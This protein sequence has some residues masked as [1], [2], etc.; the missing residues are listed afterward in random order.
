VPTFC[1]HNRFLANCPICSSD[2]VDAVSTRRPSTPK[3]A[4]GAGRAPSGSAARG[5]RSS[6]AVR[7]RQITRE[8]EDGFRSQ[9]VPGVK[10][11]AAAER[12]A[13]EIAFACARLALLA[14]DPPG[15][16]G[17]IAG[18][19][20]REEAL[21]LAFLTAYL[22][23][24]D[25]EDPFAGVRAA[26][27]P[28]ASGQ[29]PQLDDAALGPR[30]A[31]GAARG[32]ATLVA[33]RAWAERSGSQ[34]AAF[35]GEAAW[36]PERRFA[37]A[38]ERLALPGLH[39]DARFDLLVTLGQLGLLD[40]RAGTLQL[41][42]ADETT[43]AAKRVFGI[44][45]TLLLERRASCRSRRSTSRCGTGTARRAPVPPASATAR[46]SARSASSPTP[47]HTRASPLRSA[48]NRRSRRSIHPRCT[49]E[50]AGQLLDVQRR[51]HAN[52]S[53]FRCDPGRKCSRC[54]PPL[55]DS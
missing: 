37:R 36:S 24:L 46:R 53:L 14:G 43:V 1:R 15:L 32:A 22:C 50:R 35:A 38:F 4:G 27:V 51:L 42:G 7:V 23:P 45:D 49:G 47:T 2:R 6:G 18:L 12:L 29:L 21:W 8:Q 31:H 40:M 33:Y 30:T 19:E 28:W 41:G 16:Y 54:S 26:H 44:A 52:C 34:N 13:E 5:S 11:S 9:L 3:P 55:T 48:C 10:A 17:E 39:R 25:E 20:D